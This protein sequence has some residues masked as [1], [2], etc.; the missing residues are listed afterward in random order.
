MSAKWVFLLMLGVAGC[1]TRQPA[2]T[3]SGKEV[4]TVQKQVE[5]YRNKPPIWPAKGRLVVIA[6]KL[7][8]IPT[9][10]FGTL[11]I[12]GRDSTFI[13]LDDVARLEEK[14][15]LLV[16]PFKLQVM[17]R[18]GLGYTFVSVRRDRLVREIRKL[19]GEE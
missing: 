19:Q 5:L 11:H 17:T 8:F 6:D 3:S 7:V 2:Y 1:A 4:L 18:D 16:F 12:H 9:P 14:K 13:P 15:W 10:H